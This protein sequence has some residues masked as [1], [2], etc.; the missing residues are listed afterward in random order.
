[1]CARTSPS[2]FASYLEVNCRAGGITDC[3]VGL[4]TPRNDGGGSEAGSEAREALPEDPS[5]GGFGVVR[6]EGM[7]RGKEIM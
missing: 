7:R 3:H 4:W 5:R 1:M 6:C 2:R